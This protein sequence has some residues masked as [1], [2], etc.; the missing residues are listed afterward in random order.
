[1]ES[2][3]FR[4]VELIAHVKQIAEIHGISLKSAITYYIKKL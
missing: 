4:D 1:M 2:L 3:P